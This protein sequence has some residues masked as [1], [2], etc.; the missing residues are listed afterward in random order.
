MNK[1]GCISEQRPARLSRL[2]G[3]LVAL[4]LLSAAVPSCLAAGAKRDTHVTEVRFWSSGEITRVAIQVSGEFQFKSDRLTGPA[5]IFFDI[6][7][8][9]PEMVGKGIKSLKVG[10]NLLKQIRIAENQPGSTRVVLDVEENV[11]FTAAQLSNPERLMIELRSSARPNRSTAP[12]TPLVS[13][14]VSSNAPVVPAASA[15]QAPVPVADVRPASSAPVAVLARVEIPRPDPIKAPDPTKPESSKLD[16][17]PATPTPGANRGIEPTPAAKNANGDRSLTRVLGLKLGRVVIDAGHGGNDPGTRGKSGMVEKDLTLD[18]AKRLAIL[19]RDRLGSEVVLTRSDD[20]YVGLE[21]RTK[22]ANES[23]ADLFLSIHANSS[24]FK[25]VAGIETY[26]LNFNSTK[27][28][29]ELAARENAT[30]SRS[31]GQLREVLSQIAL[32]AKLAESRELALRVQSNLHSAVLKQNKEARDR[33][34]KKAPFVVLIGADMPSVLAEIGYLSNSRDEQLLRTPEHRERIAEAL[35]KGI[36]AY[37]ESL[38]KLQVAG[39]AK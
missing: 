36:A 8:A 19:V 28:D 20:T 29:T 35:Y 30:S 4:T 2:A 26:Y 33:G 34:V 10:D 3:T 18:I 6:P 9:D 16:L 1:A 23:K 38:S 15:V 11:E 5:R 39:R 31:I 13:S 21:E 17:A 37:A 24:P 12:T 25:S 22:I 14:N 27:D 7:N 32:H